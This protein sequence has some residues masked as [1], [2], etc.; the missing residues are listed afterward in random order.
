M[1]ISTDPK[2]LF[3]PH[4]F[5]GRYDRETRISGGLSGRCARV[6]Y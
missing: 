2:I 1:I 3:K 4:N 5:S 6:A